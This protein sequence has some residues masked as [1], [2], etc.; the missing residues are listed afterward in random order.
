[1]EAPRAGAYNNLLSQARVLGDY[2]HVHKSAPR[3]APP[4]PAP[5]DPGFARLTRFSRP[6][7]RVERPSRARHAQ[8]QG[9]WAPKGA[10]RR[11]QVRP[12]H[13]AARLRAGMAA[14]L[15]DRAQCGACGFPNGPRGGAQKL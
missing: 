5:R 1:M 7:V 3:S 15:G 4:L 6:R 9:G 10:P 2:T 11:R 12:Q 13:R 8:P 14:I